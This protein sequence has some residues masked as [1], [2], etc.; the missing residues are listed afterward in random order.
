MKQMAF[1]EYVGSI[2]T[3]SKQ[4]I[5]V[6]KKVISNNNQTHCMLHVFFRWQ[7]LVIFIPCTHTHHILISVF[8]LTLFLPMDIPFGYIHS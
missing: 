7:L 4:V 1:S 2:F 5:T 6:D 8:Y 3:A